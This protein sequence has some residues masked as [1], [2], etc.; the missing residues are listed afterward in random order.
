[1]GAYFLHDGNVLIQKGSCPDGHER[2]Q[3]REGLTLTLGEPPDHIT[4]PAP[5]EPTYAALRFSAYPSVGDQLD[6]LWK[7]GDALAEMHGRVLAVK[8]LYPKPVI[9]P[10]PT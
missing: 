1:M 2:H 7:G 8:T 4:W 5:P 6:A 9:A 10:S 3:G